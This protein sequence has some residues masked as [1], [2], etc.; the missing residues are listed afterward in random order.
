[1]I[2]YS[3]KIREIA[4]KLLEEGTVD[5]FIG[6]RKG[7]LCNCKLFDITYLVNQRAKQK[8]VSD[9]KQRFNSGGRIPSWTRSLVFRMNITD[10]E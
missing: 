6:Y 1:M 5:I 2:E 8:T 9:A 10:A 3:E 7:S 4:K